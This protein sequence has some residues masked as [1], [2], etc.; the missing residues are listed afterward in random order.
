M[1]PSG[2]GYGSV[3]GWMESSKFYEIKSVSVQE[4]LLLTSQEGVRYIPNTS[5]I[6][7]PL[8]QRDGDN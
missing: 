1:D 2:S 7:L 3:P 8:R 4:E 5:Y 6:E